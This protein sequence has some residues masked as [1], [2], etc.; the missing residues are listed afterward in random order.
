MHSLFQL[1]SLIYFFWHPFLGLDNFTPPTSPSGSFSFSHS[2]LFQNQLSS[3]ATLSLSSLFVFVYFGL[4]MIDSLSDLFD[5]NEFG[6]SNLLG[7]RW[8]IFLVSL[9]VLR[10]WLSFLLLMKLWLG[11][12]KWRD[13]EIGVSEF[14]VILQWFARVGDRAWIITKEQKLLTSSEEENHAGQH[15]MSRI[16]VELNL[17]EA[18]E[19]ALICRCW[20]H[21]CL[22]FISKRCVRK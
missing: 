11:W 19:R 2:L 8:L 1:I 20:D 17:K 7:E 14:Y 21:L 4:K 18:H 5:E 3:F 13:S 10:M 15:K 22:A 12:K 9:R 16:T 6:E